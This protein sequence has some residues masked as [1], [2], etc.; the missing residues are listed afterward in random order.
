MAT[1]ESRK[2][3]LKEDIKNILEEP[4]RI[5]EEEPL[6][7]IF[8]GECMKTRDIQK[9]LRFSKTDLNDISCREDEDTVNF[10]EKMNQ[11]TRA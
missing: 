11:E 4:W 8:T 2:V 3:A 10:L 6:C 1:R 7:K 9:V 5:E